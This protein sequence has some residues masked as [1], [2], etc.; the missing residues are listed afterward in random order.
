MPAQ[1]AQ[2]AVR[3]PRDTAHIEQ[4]DQYSLRRILGIWTAAALPMGILG[5][6]VAPGLAAALGSN[7]VAAMAITRL[8][9]LT[10]GLMWLVALSAIV[11]Y[12]EE[13]N[14]RWTT[15][16]RRLRL[17]TPRDPRTG[18]PRRRLWLWAIPLLL[19]VATWGLLLAPRVTQVWTSLSP[20][21]TEPS[22]FALGS[23]LASPAGRAQFAGA[24]GVLALFALNATFNVLGEELLFRGVLLPRMN[25]V[26][27]RGDWLANG[28]LFGAYHLH[29]PWGML[30]SVGTGA[31]LYALPAKYFSSTWMSIIA[32]SGQSVYFLL[33]ILGLVLGLA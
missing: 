22:G 28:V 27:G 31:L 16:R 32:H 17:N 19:L 10:V 20:L 11:V 1:I 24:W 5:W 23:A 14:I 15:L 2:S 25:R 13:G 6:I 21:L 29:Q 3:H 26:F 7:S 33:V 12:R 30:A 9:A 4:A 18:E 8:G